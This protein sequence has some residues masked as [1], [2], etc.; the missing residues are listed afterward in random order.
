MWC[1]WIFKTKVEIPTEYWAFQDVFSKQLAS[2]L[3][4]HQ[5]WDCAI[6]LH[7]GAQFPKDRTYTLSIYE[8]K[9]MEERQSIRD[10]HIHS[11]TSPAVS[12]IFFVAKKKGGFQP[13]IDYHTLNKNT[14][15]YRYLL[16]HVLSALE[17][18]RGA[19]IFMKLDLRSTYNLIWEMSG[20]LPS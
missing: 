18:M 11:S 19:T 6:E 4:P 5:P 8:Q 20:R 12:I 2:K 13:F 3:P 17:I 10:V 14:I 9:A 1:N 15:K 7:L 16:P